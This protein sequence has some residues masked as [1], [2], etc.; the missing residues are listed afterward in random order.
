MSEPRTT[1]LD[2]LKVLARAHTGD[3]DGVG[4][5]VMPMADTLSIGQREYVEAWK[6][7]REHLQLQTDAAPRP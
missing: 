7:V 4:F 6:I 1:L 2:A 5:V 3:D